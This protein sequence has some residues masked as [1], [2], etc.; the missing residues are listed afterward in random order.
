[1]QALFESVPKMMEMKRLGQL[2]PEQEKLV[3]DYGRLI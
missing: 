3:S 1:M 2:K